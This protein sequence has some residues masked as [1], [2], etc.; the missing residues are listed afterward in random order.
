MLVPRHLVKRSGVRSQEQKALHIM[1]KDGPPCR[2]TG[3]QRKNQGRGFSEAAVLGRAAC[4]F[5]LW[6]RQTK[7]IYTL[8]GK[9]QV[10]RQHPKLKRK[11]IR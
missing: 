6:W 5:P 11:K 10:K 9:L 7:G 8:W 4:S 2:E 3:S 1:D